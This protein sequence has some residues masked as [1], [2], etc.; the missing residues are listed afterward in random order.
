MRTLVD[1]R[2][3]EEA[4]RFSFR[5][6]CDDCVHFD[7]GGPVGASGADNVTD[8]RCSLRYPAAPRRTAL[9][10]EHVELCKEFELGT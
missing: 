4:E 1:A 7:E 9:A 5:F 8:R 10:D 2:L 6:A 3:R